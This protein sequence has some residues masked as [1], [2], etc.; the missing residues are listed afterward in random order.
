MRRVLL[1]V[2]IM[3]VATTACAELAFDRRDRRDA[4]RLAGQRAALE[5]RMR[6]TF[7]VPGRRT[8]WYENVRGVRVAGATAHIRTNIKPNAEGEN[9]ALPIC[10]A[11]LEIS[12]RRV[13]RVVVYGRG[14]VLD[15]C[16]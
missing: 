9:F 13:R 12:P 4:G 14:V 2:V 3:A 10:D 8:P 15:S 1:I 5:A 6:T 11:V 16:A 7:G